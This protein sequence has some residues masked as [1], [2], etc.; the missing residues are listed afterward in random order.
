ML[1][2]DG[3]RRQPKLGILLVSLPLVITPLSRIVND[4]IVAIK[5]M[6]LFVSNLANKLGKLLGCRRWV[7]KNSDQIRIKPDFVA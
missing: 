6:H 4:Q 7:R 1:V 2:F 3:V 5:A